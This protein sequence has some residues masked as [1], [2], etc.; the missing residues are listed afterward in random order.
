MLLF[1]P[2]NNA[3]VLFSPPLGG[4]KGLSLSY[5]ELRT[6]HEINT[7]IVKIRAAIGYKK[8]VT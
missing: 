1:F 8:V 3:D 5:L 2:K 6:Q 7:V 4:W